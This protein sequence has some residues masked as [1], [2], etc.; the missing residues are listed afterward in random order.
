MQESRT[1][2]MTRT[3]R[4]GRGGTWVVGVGY[5]RLYN[6]CNGRCTDVG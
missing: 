4:V 2:E 5:R 1:G 3:R 6:L